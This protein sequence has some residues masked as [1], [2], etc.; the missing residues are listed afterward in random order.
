[1]TDLTPEVETAAP[2]QPAAELLRQHNPNVT[3]SREVDQESTHDFEK[4][5]H[6]ISMV[7][8]DVE[9]VNLLIAEHPNINAETGKQGREWVDTVR[10]GQY[11]L[12]HGNA[13]MPA[14]DRTDSDWQ[15]HVQ[16]DTE[17]LSAGRPR[18][19]ENTGSLLTG[20]RAILKA[21]AVMSLGALV[22][23]PLWHTGIWISFKAPPEE[24]LLELERRLASEKVGLGRLTNG[25]IFSNTSIYTNS[26][27]I[28]FALQYVYE[29][30]HKDPSP[31]ALKA[32][33]KITDIPTLIWGLLCAIYPN[34][35]PYMRACLKVGCAYVFKADLSI[36]KLS[37][38]DNQSLTEWQRKLMSR[39]NTKVSDD[40]LA[41][42]QREHV[43][44]GTR[45]FTV[46]EDRLDIELSTPTIKQ[47]EDSGFSW[48]DSINRM[49]EEA[50]GVTL[51][52][53]E[54]QRYI[55][56]Q[57]RVTTLRQY[58][59]WV[60]RIRLAGD[61]VGDDQ[62]TLEELVA[63]FSSDEDVSKVFFTEVGR[64][65]DDATLS[66]IALPKH[67]CPV[68]KTGQAPEDN[69]H[70]YLIPIDAGKVFF[71]LLDQRISKALL[72]AQM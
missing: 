14:L 8:G 18:F 31:D 26:Y 37:W 44:G 30:T 5:N 13:L 2:E 50:F 47:Y 1:M 32:L 56:D 51:K 70:P 27:L 28:N 65:I 72:R 25:S 40:E 60:S 6:H 9:D 21:R 36:P 57:S 64:F 10:R 67:S 71:T 54:R 55:T 42:Y 49:M 4:P 48:I 63:L 35:Y 69:K 20:E 68:C 58:G 53:E 29:S 66:L 24:A 38:T 59:H 43:R 61:E 33:I 23:I 52:G 19:A 12:V 62:E 17:R 34:R 3:Q 46:A 15:Q 7:N 41:R 11:F 45:W 39:R 22:Q 16:V